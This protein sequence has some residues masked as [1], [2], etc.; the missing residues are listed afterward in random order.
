MKLT[1]LG[2]GAAEGTPSPYCNCPT[3]EHARANGG[4]NV[5]RRQ[6]VLINDNLLVDLGPDLFASCAQLGV[7]LL[8]VDHLLVTHSHLDHFDPG[9]LKLRSKGF[10]LETDLPELT[11]VAGPSV[12]TLWDSSGGSDAA[13]QIRRVPILPGRKVALPAYTVEAIEASHNLR[14]GD[15]MNYIIGD[16]SVSLLY[17]SDTGMY[18]ER[19]WRQLEGKT[20]DAVVMEATILNRPSGREHLNF[21]DFEAMLGKLRAIGA[22]HGGTAVVATHFSHQGAGTYDEI[23]AVF[24]NIGVVCAYDGLVLEVGSTVK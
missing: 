22:V 16:G 5:R 11:M 24:R 2:T 15:A 7:S 10:R 4:R 13:S 17:A 14:I 21:G 23:D 19:A 8:K 12:W 18:D 3:C 20:F 6:S 9:N 1:F